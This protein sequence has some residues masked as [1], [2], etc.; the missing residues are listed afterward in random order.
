MST[1]PQTS[2]YRLPTRVLATLV[3]ATP[4]STRLGGTV[5]TEAAICWA[6]KTDW[7]V[8]PIELDPPKDGEVLVKLAASGLCHSDEHILTGDSGPRAFP[9]V[10]G[11]EGAGTVVEVGQ[12]VSSFRPG[13]HVVF[14]F[15]PACGECPSCAR[16]HSN[17]CDRGA[18]LMKGY[19]LD[20]T[21][22]MHARGQDLMAMVCL[23][24]F[25]KYTVVNQASCVKID[26][27][28]P[29]ELAALVGCGVT[30]GWGSAVYSAKVQPGDSVAVIGIGGI[31]AAAL[32]G[33]RMAGA[34]R[35]FA[36]DPVPLKREL[37]PHFGATHVSE[38]IEAAFDL[39]QRET[40]GRMCD[41]VICAMGVGRGSLIPSIMALTAKR[42]RVVIT[43]I[44]PAAETEVNLN[45][46]DLTVMEKEIVGA[47]FGSSNIRYDIPHLLHL[48]Q[49]GQLDLEGMV[50]NRY[51]LEDVNQGYQD[52][53]D[54]K[55][56]RGILV[57]E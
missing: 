57:Y 44:H 36:I 53:R 17:L 49:V 45:L 33:A 26:G 42:G 15:V 41:K 14:G 52:M 3:N 9:V 50:T 43:N 21:S 37:A 35:I 24:T 5:Q 1:R 25:S 40:W 11:H 6:E 54:G 47:L 38:S 27:D 4:R 48:Y 22:R 51:K 28:I 10:G 19:Q 20:G 39:I 13:D 32:Q 23:G 8:E 7:S 12:G 30:T 2:Q 18:G 34:E 31:G 46:R 16:G 55:N 29:L 56:I